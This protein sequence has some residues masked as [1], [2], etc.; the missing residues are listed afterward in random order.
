MGLITIVMSVFCYIR[1]NR[2]YD[3]LHRIEL[4]MLGPLKGGEIIFMDLHEGGKSAPG[5]IK[6][7]GSLIVHHCL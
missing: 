5:T 3:Y 4:T 2:G 1:D 7:V 6:I